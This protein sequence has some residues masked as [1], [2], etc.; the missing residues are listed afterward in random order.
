MAQLAVG[1]R[2]VGKAVVHDHLR[3]RHV[4]RTVVADGEVDAPGLEH[5][6]L[7]RQLLD[8]R[9][10][11][12]G[13]PRAVKERERRER[14]CDQGER[15][16]AQDPGRHPAGAPPGAHIGARLHQATTSNRPIQPSCANSD[17]C[18]WNMYWPSYGKR[19]SR[20]PRCPW[21]CMIVSVYSTGSSDV[22]VG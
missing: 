5:G 14:E 12:V 11:A 17:W 22:P 20:M 7:H 3:E 19:S 10:L 1:G 8:R 4:V 16:G 21:H 9:A 15:H 2:E 18:A 6:A 13:Q